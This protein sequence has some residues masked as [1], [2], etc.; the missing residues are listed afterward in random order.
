MLYFRFNTDNF[1]S[2]NRVIPNKKENP[3]LGP[4]GEEDL[5]SLADI[6]LHFYNL[7]NIE[8]GLSIGTGI[9]LYKEL[10]VPSDSFVVNDEIAEN[11]I[12]TFKFT[13]EEFSK[14]PIRE[15]SNKSL[16]D[17]GIR[18]DFCKIISN[19]ETKSL[20]ERHIQA[21]GLG[22]FTEEVLWKNLTNDEKVRRFSEY[23]TKISSQN[24]ELII[25]DPYLFKDKSD[26]YCD[27]LTAIIVSAKASSIVVVTDKRN[28]DPQSY[29]KITRPLTQTIQVKYSSDFHDRFWIANRSK[30]FYCGTSLN[31][32]GKRISLINLLSEYDVGEIIEELMQQS[33]LSF[34][35]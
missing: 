16:Q 18:V 34:E 8:L 11:N 20:L 26:D 12:R 28:Y 3:S 22:Y 21:E 24:S 9:L 32:I 5:L 29:N 2:K 35:Q 31:G 19:E 33:I 10:G 15:L 1:I 7:L 25:V 13:I 30:G 14:K 27:L 4:L 6:E 23:F 17:F